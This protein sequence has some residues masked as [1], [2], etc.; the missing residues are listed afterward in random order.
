V[1]GVAALRQNRAMSSDTARR[2]TPDDITAAVEKSLEGCSDPRVREVMQALVRH[3]HAF[4]T[5]ARLTEDEWR[6]RKS[7]V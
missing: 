7:V 6:D 3:M 1:A 4:V 2:T 5:E